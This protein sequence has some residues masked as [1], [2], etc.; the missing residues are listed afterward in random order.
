M[1]DVRVP[2]ALRY[3]RV[4]VSGEECKNINWLRRYYESI[5]RSNAAVTA[6]AAVSANNL[7]EQSNS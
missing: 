3:C 7:I 6:L 2:K 1:S 5:C 4:V